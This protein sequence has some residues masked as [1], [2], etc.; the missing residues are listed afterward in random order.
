[1][2][3]IIDEE[4]LDKTYE[5]MK[6]GKHIMITDPAKIHLFFIA[7]RPMF[8]V[9]HNLLAVISNELQKYGFEEDDFEIIDYSKI[10][11]PEIRS[12]L[13]TIIELVRSNDY[14]TV[15]IEELLN[16]ILS[17]IKISEEIT[18]EEL[19]NNIIKLINCIYKNDFSNYENR[20]VKDIVSMMESNDLYINFFK[21]KV[22]MFFEEKAQQGSLLINKELI[23]IIMNEFL[24]RIQ[25]ITSS[26]SLN[27]FKETHLIVDP[28]I[29][30]I[31][32]IHNKVKAANGGAKRAQTIRELMQPIKNEAIK[33][34]NSP[35][36]ANRKRWKS[37]NEFAQYFCMNHNKK[38][39]DESQWIKESTVKAWIKEFLENG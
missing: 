12:H 38:I 33:I 20:I 17:K 1:M 31:I 13:I 9:L 26:I 5:R 35:H 27:L 22:N 18:K 7:M 39:E 24:F 15:T 37:R 23:D 28:K 36:L 3:I 11:S 10:S 29:E 34:Y 14:N 2:E 25:P 19:E 21:G 30:A 16:G 8:E 4:L 32:E 6:R